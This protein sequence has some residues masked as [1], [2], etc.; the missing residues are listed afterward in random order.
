MKTIIVY[1]SYTGNTKCI[2][3][4]YAK[5]KKAELYEIKDQKR[6]GTFSAYAAG[7][8]RAM[9]QK[10]TPI[11]AVDVD[12]SSYDKIIVMAPVWAGHPA[13][14]FNSLIA[15]LPKGTAVELNMISASGESGGKD[16]VIAFVESKGCAVTDYVDIKR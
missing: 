6:P 16:R 4:Q 1:Y 3:E 14:P 15:L 8:F 10:A 11:Q 13:P 7:C 2:A 5:A 9:R 12:F